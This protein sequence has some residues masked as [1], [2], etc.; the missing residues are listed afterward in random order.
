MK[1]IIIITDPHIKEDE[2]TECNLVFDEILKLKEESHAD[3]FI[4]AGDSFDRVNP[5]PEEIDCFSTFLS[6][7]NLPTI[8]IAAK[9]HESISDNESILKHFGILKSSIK[10]VPE[11]IDEKKLFVGHFIVNESKKKF[12]A[13]RSKTELK[14]QYVVLGHSHSFELIPPNICQLGS[15]RYINFDEA[16]DKTKKV[17]LITD[18]NGKNE[19]CHFIDLKTPYPMVDITLGGNNE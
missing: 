7:I 4:C 5:S 1:N 19:R 18:Y 10:V 2:L 8:L 16:A 9:S 14:Y 13:A 3:T 12:G 11:F 17:L 15:C 6:K